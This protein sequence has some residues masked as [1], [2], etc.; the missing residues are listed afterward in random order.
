M[1]CHKTH[2]DFDKH[3]HHN[4]EESSPIYVPNGVKKQHSV[5][6]E[7]RRKREE[8]EAA[9]E[10]YFQVIKQILSAV[11][12]QSSLSFKMRRIVFR[13]QTHFSLSKR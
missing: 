13:I 1:D 8:E 7:T 3:G 2:L 5:I 6:S 10:T 4:S 12:M 11:I 9:S